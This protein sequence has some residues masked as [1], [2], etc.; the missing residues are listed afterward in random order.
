MSSTLLRNIVL[1]HSFRKTKSNKAPSDVETIT[2][3][4]SSLLSFGDTD[5][6]NKTYEELVRSV[7][8]SGIVEQDWDPPS[9]DHKY[10]YKWRSPESGQTDDV[11]GPFS[12]DDLKSWFKAL[13]FGSSGEKIHVRRVGGNWGDWDDV[14]Q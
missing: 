13:Y 11:F 4:A 10:Q 2:H 12:E 9:A 5:I 14:V 6:Y 8:S 1:L 3:L 7:R